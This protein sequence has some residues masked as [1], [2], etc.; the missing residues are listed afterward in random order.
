[1]LESIPIFCEESAWDAAEG[2][3]ENMVVWNVAS[4]QETTPAQTPTTVGFEQAAK[5]CPVF[6]TIT[7]GN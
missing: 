5:I 7:G 6:K 4:W 1:V 2:I 3:Y